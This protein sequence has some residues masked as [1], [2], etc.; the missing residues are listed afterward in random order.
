MTKHGSQFSSDEI[1][2]DCM[3][4]G[5]EVNAIARGRRSREVLAIE[6]T[7]KVEERGPFLLGDSRKLNFD[8]GVDQ[9]GPQPIWMIACAERR[10]NDE[11][12]VR[13]CRHVLQALNEITYLAPEKSTV[14]GD[15]GV[16]CPQHYDNNGSARSKHG[17]VRVA[18]AILVVRGS[19]TSPSEVPHRKEARKAHLEESRPRL[20]DITQTARCVVV[21]DA[22]D[23]S[24]H[25]VASARTAAK[26]SVVERDGPV[27]VRRA[28]AAVAPQA[29]Q[30]HSPRSMH[31]SGGR[32]G[33]T[34]TG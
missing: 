8:A 14:K 21:A 7:L 33:G 2:D 29:Y 26:G 31:A 25:Q 28:R 1:G 13:Q 22:G 9:F 27:L 32:G 18:K 34:G 16:V 12:H 24:G 23:R 11:E 19:R 17:G 4:F 3:A 30:S 15:G 10:R 6:F 20:L 5:G